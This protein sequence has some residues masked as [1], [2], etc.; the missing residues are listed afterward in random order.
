[1]TVGNMRGQRRQNNDVKGS[2]AIK[3]GLFKDRL[4]IPTD[5]DSV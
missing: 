5:W 1:M 4:V 2:Y 3:V